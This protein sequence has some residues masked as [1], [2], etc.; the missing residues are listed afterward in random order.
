MID[1]IS[2]QPINWRE[3]IPPGWEG[4]CAW[5]RK[6][7]TEAHWQA[8]EIIALVEGPCIVTVCE[9]HY[10]NA[11]PAV[12]TRIARRMAVAMHQEHERLFAALLTDQAQQPEP[13]SN[14]VRESDGRTHQGPQGG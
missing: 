11:C 1:G 2:G 12:R 14:H 13:R 5:C 10:R 3:L 4:K 9:G 8:E 7:H 6:R